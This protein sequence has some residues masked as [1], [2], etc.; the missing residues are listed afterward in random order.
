MTWRP[1]TEIELRVLDLIRKNPE[2][3]A[4]ELLAL[5]PEH[6][7]IER[8][9]LLNAVGFLRERRMILDVREVGDAD[10]RWIYHSEV[11]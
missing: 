11:P 8:I 9:D 4:A 3:T 6:T 1:M 2:K 7:L 10:S 5:Q